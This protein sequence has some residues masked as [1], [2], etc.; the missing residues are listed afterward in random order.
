MTLKPGGARVT[1]V[2]GLDNHEVI[3]TPRNW[4]RV[5]K[6]GSLKIRSRGFS[7]DG[8]QWEYWYFAGGMDGELI[9]EYG[10]DGGQGFVGKLRDAAIQE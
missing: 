4:S 3:L 9:V 7:E 10:R 8:F 2:W 5:K 1:V 6:G